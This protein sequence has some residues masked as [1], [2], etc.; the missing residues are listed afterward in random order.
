[1]MGTSAAPVT[2]TDALWNE[3]TRTIE[4]LRQQTGLCVYEDPHRLDQNN[5]I[6]CA[7]WHLRYNPA[8]VAQM[9][10]Q[11]L[12]VFEAALTAHQVWVRSIETWWA[13]RRT[14][15]GSE[16]ARLLRRRHDH[17]KDQGHTKKAREDAVCANEPEA[18]T[19]RR[20]WVKAQAIATF[21]GGISA[22]FD[23]L[24]NCLKRTSDQRQAE[25]R[26]TPPQRF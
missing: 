19:L 11:Q 17:Y 15:L 13:A 10:A 6:H 21:L 1:M 22:K 4:E 12:C 23:S 5:P 20:E 24:E 16:L 9:T 26:R 18:E 2:Q 3:I 25:E 14:F 7:L 8:G